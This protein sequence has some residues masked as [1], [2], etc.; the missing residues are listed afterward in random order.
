MEL[1]QLA[2]VI[3]LTLT[4]AVG[5]FPTIFIAKF[6]SQKCPSSKTIIDLIYRDCIFFNYLVTFNFSIGILGCLI[7]HNTI[8]DF[9]P[10]FIIAASTGIFVILL[11]VSLFISGLL[12]LLTL[13][14]KSEEFGIQLLGPDGIAIWVVRA[15]SF[16]FSII[17]FLTLTFGF[18]ILPGSFYIFYQDQNISALSL[19]QTVPGTFIY[20]LPT[21][22]AIAVNIIC[23]LFSIYQKYKNWNN[24]LSFSF[25]IGSTIMFT[26]PVIIVTAASF[27]GRQYRLVF[28]YPLLLFSCIV[29]IPVYIIITND[30]MK[31]KMIKILSDTINKVFGNLFTHLQISNTSQ[32]HP[33]IA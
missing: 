15:I 16:T 11:T 29:I 20:F 27:F 19:E 17:L 25:S 13:I 8:L 23:K 33:I 12:R 14:S 31:T 24:S 18:Q 1:L 2:S 22:C 10:A 32:V 21:V 3:F 6:F 9:I 28:V 4:L 30:K 7:S 26:F 5:I